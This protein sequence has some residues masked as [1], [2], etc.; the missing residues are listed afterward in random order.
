MKTDPI[1]EEI[2]N[3]AEAIIKKNGGTLH[4]LIRLLVNEQKRTRRVVRLHSRPR[5]AATGTE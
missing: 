2:R 3:N 1:V 4:D 5:F